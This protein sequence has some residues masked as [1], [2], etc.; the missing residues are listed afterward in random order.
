MATACIDCMWF[1]SNDEKATRG[2]CK[3]YPPTMCWDVEAQVP[4]TIA[5]PVYEPKTDYCGDFE[6]MTYEVIPPPQTRKDMPA[7]QPVMPM[8]SPEDGEAVNVS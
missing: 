6:G 3:R 8:V 1:K 7:A 2:I 5:T 4:V